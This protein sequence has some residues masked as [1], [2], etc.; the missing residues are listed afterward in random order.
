MKIRA[1]LT[2]AFVVLGVAIVALLSIAIGLSLSRSLESELASNAR[3]QL[4]TAEQA[5]DI[6]FDQSRSTLAALAANPTL[7]GASGKL[8]KYA[9]TSVATMPDPAGYG[10]QESLA[11]AL[12]AYAAAASTTITQVE[13]GMSDGGYLIYPPAER[14]PGYD[15]RVRPWYMTAMAAPEDRSRTDARLTSDGKL[16]ISLLERVR[17]ASGKVAG[18]ASL[19]ISLDKLSSIAESLR[20]GER[21]YVILVQP[22]GRILADPRHPELVFKNVSELP[23]K[24]YALAFAAGSA[25][26][27]IGVGADRYLS[28]ARDFPKLGFRGIGLV[29][30]AE[31]VRRIRAVISLLLAIALP[32]AIAAAIAGRV[33]ASS[34]SRPIAEAVAAAESISAGRLA[35]EIGTAGLSRKDELGLLARSL[36]SMSARLSEVVGRIRNAAGEAAAGAEQISAASQSLSQGT[37]EQA[38]NAEE[39]SSAMEKLAASTHRNMESS[40]S[41]EGMA[42]EAAKA[43]GEGAKAVMETVEAMK[44][45]SRSIS[46]IEDIARQT[47][48]LALNAAIEAARAGEAGKGFAVVAGEIRKLAE[49]SRGSSR[50]I[51][52]VSEGFVVVAE[53]AGKILVEVVPDI[54]RMARMMSEI[55]S[56]SREQS[57]GEDQAT[58]AILK[59]D[60]TIQAAASASEE[61]AASSSTLSS[62]SRAL[63][64]TV[65]YFK[66]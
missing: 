39:V 53:R 37:S 62:Q 8:A 12:F 30:Q 14:T 46:I 36:G 24:G 18:V 56:A 31:L 6:F 34:I 27:R 64:E 33:I 43:A 44:G 29:D 3:G 61:L 65:S 2:L 25:E 52:S 21:G 55:A 63:E 5:L 17:D 20:V 41:I 13:L 49:L 47:N 26:A 9:G 58:K 66:V 35:T 51:A 42:R 59:L 7:R 32:T 15:P 10:I 28:V 1:K 57:S 22:D 48:L 23:E 50:E 40:I 19:S 60:T 4:S 54:E 38:A 16:A 45:I 11:S